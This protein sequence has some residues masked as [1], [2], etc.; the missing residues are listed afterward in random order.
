M[1]NRATEYGKL[2]IER[3]SKQWWPYPYPSAVNVN[4]VEGFWIE[5]HPHAFFYSE[6]RTT[7]P[8]EFRL[9]GNTL[10]WERDGITFRVESGLDQQTAIR[11]AESIR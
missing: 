3:Y 11:I 8:E 6:G 10:L 2:A 5:G 9:V 7:K 4:G 1:W